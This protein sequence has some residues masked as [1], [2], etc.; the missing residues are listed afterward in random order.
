MKLS[1]IT[2]CYNS[3]KTILDTI[4]SV[5]SQ[6]YKNIEHVFV[7]GGSTDDTISLIKNNPNKKKILIRKKTSI[8]EAMN[9]GIKFSS[10]SIIQILN[11]DDILHSNTSIENVIVKIKKFPNYSIYLGNVIFFSNNNFYKIKRY[12]TSHRNR[13]KNL[14]FGDMPPHPSSF[15]KKKIYNKYGMYN[16][17]FNIASDYDFFLRILFINKEK[18]KILNQDIVRMRSGGASDNNIKSYAKISYEIFKSLKLNKLKFNKFKIAI[19]GLNKIK[20]LYNFDQIKLNKKFKIFNFEYAQD[21][22]DKNCF[23]IIKKLSILNLKKNFI[24]SGMN[25]AFLGYYSKKNVY[26]HKSM[27]HWPDG[28]FLKNIIDINKIPGREI[29][30]QIK[31]PRNINKIHIIGNLSKISKNYLKKK[32]NLKLFQTKLPYASI[33]QLAKFNIK[34]KKNTITFITLPTPKQEQLAYLLAK[35]NKYYKIICIGGSISIASGEEKQVPKKFQDYEFL[36]RLN[37]DFFRRS[38]RLLESLYF[39]L[40]GKY[41]NNL[42]NQTIFRIIEK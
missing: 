28:I 33:K 14:P 36:W 37:T 17:E 31:I 27:Y 8:Y 42:Y 24:L 26:P 41:L 40:K 39:Y 19:R 32:F 25:L 15:I 5:N 9:E 18:Y 30:R 3:E 21:K 16:T 29:V 2:V 34:L 4:N 6:T 35:K 10:G 11:S 13:V 22:Y 1:I 12:Y 20:E 38:I 7:D 23:K